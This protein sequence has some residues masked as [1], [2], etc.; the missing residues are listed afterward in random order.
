MQAIKFE[1]IAGP[2][3]SPIPS[4]MVEAFPSPSVRRTLFLLPQVTPQLIFYT[5]PNEQLVAKI[6]QVHHQAI[7]LE[8]AG[9]HQIMG[10]S[11]Q[12]EL[13]R[14]LIGLPGYQFPQC[15]GFL[16]VSLFGEHLPLI[17]QSSSMEERD[18]SLNDWIKSL[19]LSSTEQHPKFIACLQ[20]LQTTEFP[21][22]LQQLCAEMNITSRSLERWFNTFLGCSPHDFIKLIRLEHI[23][24]ALEADP[25]R[26]FADIAFDLGFADPSHFT[27][28][29]KS[30]V[31]VNPSRFRQL[32]GSDEIKAVESNR[33][34]MQTCICACISSIDTWEPK[35]LTPSICGGVNLKKEVI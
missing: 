16:P 15:K 24:N 19:N 35:A 18:Q 5:T 2:T 17:L 10:F 27:R 26:S 9:H 12:P 4:W 29:F 28:E 7:Q 20:R 14:Q 25:D 22:S 32:L 23:V 21:I 13:A 34:W 30:L 3:V 11:L 1:Q 33:V 6:F 31:G 8:V